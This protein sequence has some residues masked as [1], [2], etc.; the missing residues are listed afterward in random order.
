MQKKGFTLIELLIVIAIIG[1][2]AAIVLVSL[3]SASDKAKRTSVKSTVSSVSA[4]ATMCRNGNGTVQGGNAGGALCSVTEAN[5]GTNAR[6]QM[7]TACGYN[8]A[9]TV[10]AVTNGNDDD[11]TMELTTCANFPDCQGLEVETEGLTT[12]PAG[13]Q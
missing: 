9:D 6:L 10:Y 8:N 3:H 2:L 1:I 7:S 12:I 13:C 11:W 4:G 5:G